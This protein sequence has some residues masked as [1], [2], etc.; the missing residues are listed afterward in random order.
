LPPV[1]RPF[2]PLRT[3]EVTTSTSTTSAHCSTATGGPL[4]DIKAGINLLGL[5]LSRAVDETRVENDEGHCVS[6]ADQSRSDFEG[7]FQINDSRHVVVMDT[8]GNF[9]GI[10]F[11]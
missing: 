8:A 9:L 7:F 4:K 6:H 3:Y 10:S 1:A 2:T 11:E 5:H